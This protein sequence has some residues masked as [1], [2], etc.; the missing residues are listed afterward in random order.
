MK[1][2]DQTIFGPAPARFCDNLERALR[3]EPAPVRKKLRPA[4]ILV[5]CIL[6]IA[7]SAVG[8]TLVQQLIGEW[9]AQYQDDPHWYPSGR[10]VSYGLQGQPRAGDAT[11]GQVLEIA[12]GAVLARYDVDYETLHE[13]YTVTT[14]FLDFDQPGIPAQWQDGT[15]FPGH[16]R[17]WIVYI[18]PI[19]FRTQVLEPYAVSIDP[20]TGEILQIDVG[21]KG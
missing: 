3:M 4:L 7:C 10:S 16:Q 6:L 2:Y 5:L 9:T 8:V 1:R 18:A 21:Y 19:D 15:D 14:D 13:H 17:Y 20:E 11:H 12:L